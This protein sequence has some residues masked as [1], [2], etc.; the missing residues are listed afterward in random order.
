[1]RCDDLLA[2]AG[3]VDLRSGSALEE[4]PLKTRITEMLGVEIPIVQ[5]PTPVK[6]P[7]TQGP[8]SG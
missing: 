1:M 7:A 2:R 4:A 8:G 6:L 3:V 5:A